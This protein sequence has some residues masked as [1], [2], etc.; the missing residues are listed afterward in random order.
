MQRGDDGDKVLYTISYKRIVE[1]DPEPKQEDLGP[2]FP[3]LI[4]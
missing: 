4:N 3:F 2:L 1:M